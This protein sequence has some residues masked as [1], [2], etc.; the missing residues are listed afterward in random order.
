MKRNDQ[1]DVTYFSGGKSF[2]ATKLKGKFDVIVISGVL[3]CLNNPL[4]V[5][6]NLKQNLLQIRKN[7]TNTSDYRIYRN[8]IIT[9]EYNNNLGI[10]YLFSNNLSKNK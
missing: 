10:K 6:K 8:M 9:Q 7:Y 2:D 5:I 1:I 4:T 3:S